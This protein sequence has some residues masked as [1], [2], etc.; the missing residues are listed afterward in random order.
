MSLIVGEHVAVRA[1]VLGR[2]ALHGA[3]HVVAPAVRQADD[4]GHDRVGHLD[5]RDD[6]RRSVS[7]RSPARR[8][9]A[10]AGP[11]RPDGRA[12]CTGACPSRAPGGCAS[13]SCS[14]AAGVGRRARSPPPLPSAAV[15]SASAARNRATS[16]T[17]SSGASSILPLGVRSA[18]GRRGVSASEVDPVRC[19]FEPVERQQRPVGAG[20]EAVAVR[21][22]AQH[23]VEHPLGPD[24]RRE[25][26]E[27]L[28]RLAAEH[29]RLG[30]C[31]LALD[32]QADDAVVDRR[33]V[34]VRAHAGGDAGEA[35]Q[36]D[37][38]VGEIRLGRQHRRRSS[39]RRCGPR[40]GTGRGRSASD[41]AVR[42]RA[43]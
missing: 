38:L 11:R 19:G 32:E 40:T 39:W 20:A 4:A 43:G 37:P 25:R 2:D 33:D 9:R 13:T 24:A 22:G 6:G 26:G 28:A 8:R 41:A 17:I 23:Q 35:Q 30:R 10:R 16:S 29:G 15:R 36:R 21:T 14:S 7:G 42:G 27:Q 5:L 3:G 31:D 34:R 18:S 12:A 1:R